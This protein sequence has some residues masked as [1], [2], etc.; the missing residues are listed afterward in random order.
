M[1]GVI[2]KARGTKLAAVGVAWVAVG[3][4]MVGVA[5]ESGSVSASKYRDPIFGNRCPKSGIRSMA[6]FSISDTNWLWSRV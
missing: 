3:V 5:S 1:R 4:G 2:A 6:M